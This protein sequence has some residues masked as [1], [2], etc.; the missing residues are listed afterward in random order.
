MAEVSLRMINQSLHAHLK[1]LDLCFIFV[2]STAIPW[3][4]WMIVMHD[5]KYM[6]LKKHTNDIWMANNVT[7]NFAVK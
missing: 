7:D 3:L 6:A 5:I 2:F 1:N 4:D